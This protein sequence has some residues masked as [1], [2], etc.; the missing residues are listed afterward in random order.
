MELDGEAF[1]VRIIHTLAAAVIG[2]PEGLCAD[3][4]QGIRDNRVAVVL[5]SDIGTAGRQ[6]L[7]GLVAAAMTVFQLDGV[8]A[9]GKGC[10]LVG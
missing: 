2:I 6:I 5:G 3:S 4:L 7:D 8:S 9:Q 10:Q 1:Q